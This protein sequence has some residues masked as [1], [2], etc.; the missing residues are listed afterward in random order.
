MLMPIALA[1]T[2]VLAMGSGDMTAGQNATPA[3]IRSPEAP[4]AAAT[5]DTTCRMHVTISG[6]HADQRMAERLRV[7]RIIYSRLNLVTIF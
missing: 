1:I 4:A 3:S 7:K 6:P 5:D 2:I